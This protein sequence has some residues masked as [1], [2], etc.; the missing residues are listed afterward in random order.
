M[1]TQEKKLKK[2]NME[3]NKKVEIKVLDVENPSM[4]CFQTV[5]EAK[6]LEKSLK[7]Y[8]ENHE[9]DANYLPKKDDV[10]LLKVLNRII[11]VRVVELIKKGKLVRVSTIG[12]GRSQVISNM[13]LVHLKNPSLIEFA[14]KSFRM[15]AICDVFPA[16]LVNTT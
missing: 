13:R 9:I 8:L 4:F 2:R 5:H 11:V 7:E 3:L 14:I 12:T 15:G 1:V 10:L 6:K 16:E